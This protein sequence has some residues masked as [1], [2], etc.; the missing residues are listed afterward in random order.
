MKAAL[1][2]ARRQRAWRDRQRDA[3][4]DARDLRRFQ[5]MARVAEVIARLEGPRPQ[6]QS[7]T[8]GDLSFSEY[9]FWKAL[10]W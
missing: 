3:R 2:E 8:Y 9:T 7:V 10:R 6:P 1:R 4:R 5:R